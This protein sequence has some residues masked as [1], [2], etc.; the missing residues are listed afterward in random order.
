MQSTE[1]TEN[2]GKSYEGG[3]GKPK[4]NAIVK[5]HSKIAVNGVIKEKNVS[6]FQI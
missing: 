2:G 5:K 4:Q 6:K 1:T 3:S